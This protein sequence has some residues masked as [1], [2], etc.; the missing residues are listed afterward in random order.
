MALPLLAG[1]LSINVQRLPLF[2]HRAPWLRLENMHFREPLLWA[3]SLSTTPTLFR[4][5]AMRLMIQNE[6][7]STVKDLRGIGLLRVGIL[8]TRW[9]MA[10]SI[11]WVRKTT[12]PLLCDS[13]SIAT[14]RKLSMARLST[15]GLRSPICLLH[16]HKIKKFEFLTRWYAEMV[17][18]MPLRWLAVWWLPTY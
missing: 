7:G 12:A 1:L 5:P 18:N 3:S 4:L 6:Q 15:A 10:D 14:S 11:L 2:K 9:C 8:G 13:L 16:H 17:K